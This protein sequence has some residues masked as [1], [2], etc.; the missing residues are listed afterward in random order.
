[1]RAFN[2]CLAHELVRQQR[3][4]HPLSLAF[5]DCD[6]FKQVNDHF[7]H[8]R[9][10]DLLRTVAAAIY[11]DLREVDV[12]ARLGGDEF[13]I[14]LP[15]SDVF[16]AETVAHKLRALLQEVTSEYGVTFSIG[17]VTYLVPAENTDDILHTADLAMYE[18]KRSGKNTVRHRI[19]ATS[20]AEGT[21]A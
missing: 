10:D 15:E 9:G 17:L 18:A 13:A 1:V 2:E 7:G 11:G 16:A 6:N 12:V 19:I 4:E 14:L 21:N 20:A 3:Y 5:L 8:A